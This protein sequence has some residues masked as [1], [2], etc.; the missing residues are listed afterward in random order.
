MTTILESSTG[1]TAS[2]C[3]KL[4]TISWAGQCN[5]FYTKATSPRSAENMEGFCKSAILLFWVPR[6]L[7]HIVQVQHP[8]YRPC[9]MYHAPLGHVPS[10]MQRGMLPGWNIQHFPWHAV[11]LH[12]SGS[13]PL[14]L[15]SVHWAGKLSKNTRTSVSFLQKN[16]NEVQEAMVLAWYTSTTLHYFLQWKGCKADGQAAN[17]ASNKTQF[18]SLVPRAALFSIWEENAACVSWHTWPCELTEND[19]RRV[20]VFLDEFLNFLL[21]MRRFSSPMAWL[22]CFSTSTAASVPQRYIHFQLWCSCQ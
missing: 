11:L 13:Q 18:F 14:H 8:I 20:L 1:F 6:S 16:V 22:C 2:T 12:H 17:S 3:W 7:F 21:E 9:P 19:E 10:T 4:S 15:L 5:W